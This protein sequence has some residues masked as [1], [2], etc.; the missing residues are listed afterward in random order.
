[1]GKHRMTIED[2][3]AKA[4]V[5]ISSVSRVL[6]GHLDVSERMRSKVEAAVQEL[7]YEPDYLAQSLR[8]GTT[9][10]I[11]FMIRDI[12]NPLFSMVAQ[13]AEQK[14]RKSGYS[15]IL[16][17]SDGDVESEKANFALLKRR[18]IDGVIASLVS[19]D[20]PY[21]RK[22]I[23]ELG[24]PIVLLDREVTGLNASAV[25]CDH[26]SGVHQ[27]TISLL[28]LGHQKV[29]FISGRAD[30]FIT[31]NRLKGYEDAF[32]EKAIPIDSSL[33]RLG[34]F[35]E[36]FAYEQAH[37]LLNG[38]VKP[39]ALIA[40]GI[41][42]STGT[43]KALKERNIVPGKDIAFVALDEWPMFDVLSANISS[44]Y[45]DPEEMGSQAARLILEVIQGEVP[46]Q[47]MVPTIYRERFSTYTVTNG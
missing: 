8:K 38:E 42:A 4:G 40:G 11:G 35:G 25:I 30:V 20:A 47:S 22:T 45:R 34:K 16:M 7:G 12:T 15:M 26:R 39:T 28:N 46:S 23:N 44:V 2:V 21:V 13:S 31:R 32:A 43:L 24:A 6:S 1:M 19:E 27:A 9:K 29:A 36:K 41:G 3:A 18:R 37:D 5:A 33:I 17:N 14:L 10:T